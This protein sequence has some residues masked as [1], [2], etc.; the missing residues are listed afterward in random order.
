M[1]QNLRYLF[2]ILAIIAGLAL[3]LFYGLV[4][5][6]VELVDTS[7]ESL[8]MDY[9][10]DYVLMVAEAYTIDQD[11]YL[12]VVRIAKLG[13]AHPVELVNE[14]L[15]FALESGYTPEDLVLM[16]DLAKDLETWNPD[17]GIGGP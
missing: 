12:A 8:R 17:L 3:G 13:D 1:M 11:G 15:A 9:K 4:V 2:F 6:P 5:S 10:T 7:P 14:A 16:H